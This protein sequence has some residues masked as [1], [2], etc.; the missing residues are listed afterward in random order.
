MRSAWLIALLL[1][2]G[3]ADDRLAVAPPAGVDL[4]G[5]WRLDQSESDS[6]RQVFAMLAGFA[7][8]GDSHTSPDRSGDRG[9]RGESEGGRPEEREPQGLGAADGLGALTDAMRWPGKNLVIRQVGGVVA[10]TSAGESR[11]YQPS[12]APVRGPAARERGAQTPC[13]WSGD[14]LL[15]AMR[16]D[17]DGAIVEMRYRISEDRRRLV[18]RIARAGAGGVALTRVW[19]RVP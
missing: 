18:E 14:A 19:D 7:K 9:D 11:V 16:P 15:I 10:F 6:P 1:L 2:G 4:S 3:C 13:G 8:A 5:H 12:A 17:D